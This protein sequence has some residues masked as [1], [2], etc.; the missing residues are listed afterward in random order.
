MVTYHNKDGHPPTTNSTV[1]HHSYDSH[2]I[3]KRRISYN[4]PPSLFKIVMILEN[5]KARLMTMSL[6]MMTPMST[7]S[8]ST[9][10]GGGVRLWAN[11]LLEWCDISMKFLWGGGKFLGVSHT[12]LIYTGSHDLL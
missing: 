11:F 12:F 10:E 4:P 9:W 1:T 2:P 6:L 5:S 3:S 8:T 7:S